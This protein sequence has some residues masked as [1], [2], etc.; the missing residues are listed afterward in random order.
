V[1]SK[2]RSVLSL[3]LATDLSLTQWLAALEIEIA[4]VTLT[5]ATAV[6]AAP[7][8]QTATIDWAAGVD[9]QD[10]YSTR[11]WVKVMAHQCTPYLIVDLS[12]GPTADRYPRSHTAQTPDLADPRYKT[13]HLVLRRIQPGK[14]AMGSPGDEEGRL[15]DETQHEVTLSHAFHLGVFEVTQK[16]WELVMGTRPAHFSQGTWEQ[17]PVERVSYSDIRGSCAGTGWPVSRSVGGDSFLGRLRARCG[18]PGLDLPTEAQWEYACRAGTGAALNSGAAVTVPWDNADPALDQLGRYWYNG[19]QNHRTDPVAGGTAAVGSYR[20]NAWGL[21]DMLGNVWEWCLD[22]HGT[23]PDA[24]SDPSG[25]ASGSFRVLPRRRLVQCRRALSF[26]GSAQV[27]AG[28]ARDRHRFPTGSDCEPVK[29][30]FR[31]ATPELA[32][33]EPPALKS[34]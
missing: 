33:P 23:Y 21:Y 17:R 28:R 25:V 15:A 4:H 32:A 30:G 6:T 34:G 16:Q 10:Q 20:P 26:R 24:V 19:G 9:W 31:G 1:K 13:T 11:M 5:G 14:F 8:W 7:D 29:M 27:L 12:A 2:F 3:S 22:W 18:L